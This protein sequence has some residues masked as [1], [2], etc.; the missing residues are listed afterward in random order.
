MDERVW[1]SMDER[2]GMSVHERVGKVW[3]TGFG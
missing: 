1:M 2:V 3:M